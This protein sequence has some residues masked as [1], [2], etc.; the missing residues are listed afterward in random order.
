[1]NPLYI[2]KLQTDEEQI[3]GLMFID[4]LPENRGA[5]FMY[6]KMDYNTFWMK[7]TYIPLDMIFMDENFCITA[8]VYNAPPLSLNTID[9]GVKSQYILE[10][11]AGYAKKNNLKLNMKLLLNSTHYREFFNTVASNNQHLTIGVFTL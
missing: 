11:N 8:I 1:M 6:N 2:T 5:L 4:Y 7:N 9:P 10:V 3:I